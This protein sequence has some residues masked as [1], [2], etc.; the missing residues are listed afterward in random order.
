M[1][2]VGS[3]ARQQFYNQLHDKL[4]P[5]ANQCEHLARIHAPRTLAE[6]R[7]AKIET[8]VFLKCVADCLNKSTPVERLAYAELTSRINDAIEMVLK[9]NPALNDSILGSKFQGSSYYRCE[10]ILRYLDEY[11]P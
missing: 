11:K 6:W 10:C 5:I 3:L 8:H 1:F 9:N 2:T 7:D 4:G